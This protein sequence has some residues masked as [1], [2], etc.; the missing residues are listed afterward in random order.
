MRRSRRFSSLLGL[1]SL[2]ACTSVLGIEDIHDGPR[3]G[4]GGDASTGGSSSTTGGKNTSAGTANPS[5]GSVSPEAGDGN[6]PGGG[7]NNTNAG[8]ANDA[9]AGGADTPP[10]DGPVH[11]KLIDFWGHGL[12]NLA[13][14]IGEEQVVTDADGNFTTKKDVPAEYDASLKYTRRGEDFVY[15]WVYQGLTRRDPT[16]QVYNAREDRYTIGYAMVTSVPAIG[17]NDTISAT[18]GTPDGS[19]EKTGLD[20]SNNGNYFSPEWQGTEAT[21]GTAHALLWTKNP[22]TSLPTAYKSYDSKLVA[23]AEGS[24]ADMTFALKTMT[25]TSGNLTGTVK[26]AGLGDRSNGVFA[27]FTSGGSITLADHAPSANAFSYLVPQLTNASIGI[28]ASDGDAYSGPYS[29][30]HKDGL[31]PGE[32][33]G[34][35]TIPGTVVGLGRAGTAPVDDTTSFTFN[36]GAAPARAFVVHIEAVD[37]LQ[38]LYIVTARTKFTIPQ[39]MAGAY[40]LAGNRDYFWT[41]ETHGSVTTVDDMTGPNG[42]ADSYSGATSIGG[43][44]Q[45]QGLG[46]ESGSYTVSAAAYFTRTCDATVSYCDAAK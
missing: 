43:P 2:G 27:R 31:S 12:P 1:L 25:I 8:A 5:G 35:L 44:G 42:F 11:G 41:V 18:W 9:G 6:Q 45:P 3:P 30:V 21:N 4:S 20:T 46:Q 33:A 37:F 15:G 38:Y 28:A 22:A 19:I 39:V 10:M 40:T 23:L 26:P 14:Q 36:A 24:P 13:V 29:V 7:A 17:L 16:L 32:D 34:T